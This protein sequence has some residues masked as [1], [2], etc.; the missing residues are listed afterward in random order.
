MPT[1]LALAPNSHCCDCGQPFH[2][3]AVEGTAL[4]GAPLHEP[5]WC[6]A[7]APKVRLQ[8]GKD[9]RTRDT[10]ACSKARCLC[11][12]CLEQQPDTL[13]R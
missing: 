3:G 4:T 6:Q 12:A 1:S 13:A 8:Q 11:R 10:S 2:C 5:C 7:I 9:E